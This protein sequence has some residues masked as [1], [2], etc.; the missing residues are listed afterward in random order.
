MLA[1]QMKY[2]EPWFSSF[3]CVCG[4]T[5]LRVRCKLWLLPRS[6]HTY[7]GGQLLHVHVCCKVHLNLRNIWVWIQKMCYFIINRQKFKI[8]IYFKYMWKEHLHAQQFVVQ[9]RKTSSPLWI[10]LKKLPNML[11]HIWTFSPPA[12]P[13]HLEM[14]WPWH[15]RRN[16]FLYPGEVWLFGGLYFQFFFKH[17][18]TD[19]WFF[20]GANS[21]SCV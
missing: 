6:M 8:S 21:T 15:N 16:T 17:L 10:N 7:E 13:T 14:L 19:I 20:L 4:G 11:F 5:P 2:L 12:P 1:E 9:K 18:F 3:V